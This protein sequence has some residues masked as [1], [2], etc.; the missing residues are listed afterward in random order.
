MITQELTD[1]LAQAQAALSGETDWEILNSIPPPATRPELDGAPAEYTDFLRDH[2]G[3][4][5][6]ALVILDTK[7]VA[8]AQNLIADGETDY[9]LGNAD[10]YCIGK[11]NDHPV[12]VRRQDETVWTFPDMTTTWWESED[13]R[14]LSENLGN[15]LLYYGLGPGY[16]QLTAVGPDEQ[17]QR[18][19]HH[20]GRA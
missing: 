3:V 12:V 11:V 8:A 18:L 19:L 1:A 2:D 6:G 14:Q 5:L 15:F 20:L 17:W 10:W 9:P 7:F 4:I 13:F 16:R